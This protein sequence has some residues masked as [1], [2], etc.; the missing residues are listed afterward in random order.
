MKREA[1]EKWRTGYLLRL[2]HHPVRHGVRPGEHLRQGAQPGEDRDEQRASQP[3]HSV[4]E[5][6]ARS[7]RIAGAIV[8]LYAV[9]S[10]VPLVWIFLTELQVAA[11]F[12]RLSA[13][14]VL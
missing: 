1:F 4:V 10:M 14:G 12:D 2:R 11:R 13:Q 9:V 6:V 3:P 8:I 7:K 5:P